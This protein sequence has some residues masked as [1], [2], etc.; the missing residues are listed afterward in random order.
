MSRIYLLERR[1]CIPCPLADVFP[2]FADA[3]NL[4]QLT[5]D[6]L[7]FQ[8]LTPLPIE[9]A[10]GTLIDYRIRLCGVPLRWRTRIESFEPPHRFS[11]VQ[12]RGP[13]RLWHH[14]HEF[15]ATPE[16]TLMI[17]R[18]RYGLPLGPLGSLA[19]AW[20]VHRTLRQIFDFRRRAV[21]R[22]FAPALPMAAETAAAAPSV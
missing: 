14:T 22:L 7:G 17:D 1:Q 19:H 8:I 5:P 12:I 9:M 16:G 15:T 13:Y 11:D 18:V 21:E 6:F 3:A 20:F 4:E 2:F 10:A